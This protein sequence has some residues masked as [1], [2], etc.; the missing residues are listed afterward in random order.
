M[1]LLAKRTFHFT[2]LHVR[3]KPLCMRYVSP[4]SFKQY[5]DIQ[6][7][8]PSATMD[9]QLLQEPPDLSTWTVDQLTARVTFLEQQLKDQTL[10][11]LCPSAQ[12]QTVLIA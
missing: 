9:E 3:V 8:K 7:L 4:S 12:L 5:S 2:N 1:R 10:K 11:C 6:Q